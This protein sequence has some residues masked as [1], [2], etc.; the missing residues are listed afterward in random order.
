MKNAA[1]VEQNPVG[2]ADLGAGLEVDAAHVALPLHGRHEEAADVGR[3]RL[4]LVKHRRARLRGPAVRHDLAAHGVEA[5]DQLQ[6]KKDTDFSLGS[7]TTFSQVLFQQFRDD[8][9]EHDCSK[10]LLIF[11][12]NLSLKI[13]LFEITG[14]VQHSF[15]HPR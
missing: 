6:K 9:G 8:S 10:I 11:S 14:I 2:C 15:K 13:N 3:E 7:S 5:G 12:E 4:H 1:F